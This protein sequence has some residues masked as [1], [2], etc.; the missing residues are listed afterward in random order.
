MSYYNDDFLNDTSVYMD[1][2]FF[3]NALVDRGRYYRYATQ[4]VNYD[5][6][7]KYGLTAQTQIRYC[8]TNKD[9][10][11]DTWGWYMT[12]YHYSVFHFDLIHFFLRI[13]LLQTH[14]TI[15][16]LWFVLYLEFVLQFQRA[17]IST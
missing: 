7:H 13:F 16:S 9:N 5:L 6:K 1:P 17:T 2:N 15:R 4:C 11:Q 10:S 3:T 12:K 14:L 8:I